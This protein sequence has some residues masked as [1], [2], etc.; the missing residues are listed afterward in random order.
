MTEQKLTTR[1]RGALIEAE[2]LENGFA[3][4]LRETLS[5]DPET[6]IFRWL[7]RTANRVHI[8]DEAGYINANG[9]SHGYR[10]IPLQG[11]YWA[12]HRL[13]YVFMTGTFPI[14]EVD[15]KDTDRSNNVWTN[16]RIASPNDNR[17]NRKMLPNNTS[18]FRGVQTNAQSKTKPW[19]AIIREN[20]KH[21][22]LGAF[23][24]A[25]EAAR[26]YDAKARELHG[27]Y[28]SLNFPEG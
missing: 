2:A 11:R 9:K 8:G 13:A 14:G 4:F 25:E 28:A 10:M 23:A 18:G 15:H 17:R 20:Y 19:K 21:I 7:K 26:A 24:T 1:Q 12:A 6:G 3:D 27:E 5:Y 16:L 22:Y